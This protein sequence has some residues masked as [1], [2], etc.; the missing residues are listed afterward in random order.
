MI[1]PV[2]NKE[3]FISKDCFSLQKFSPEDE[4]LGWNGLKWFRGNRFFFTYSDEEFVKINFS[5][6]DLGSHFDV[7]IYNTTEYTDIMSSKEDLKSYFNNVILKEFNFESEKWD[8]ACFNKSRSYRY[9][10]STVHYSDI[11]KIEYLYLNKKRV[12]TGKSSIISKYLDITIDYC[13]WKSENSWG[14]YFATILG[15]SD[16]EIR[17]MKEAFVYNFYK[18]MYK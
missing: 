3:G 13:I 2:F 15:E 14:D 12:I 16:P 9:D 7:V 4:N 18:K 5:I 6:Q 1:K 11:F 8:L 17:G 10:H